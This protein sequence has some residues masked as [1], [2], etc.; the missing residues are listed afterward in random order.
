MKKIKET[1]KSKLLYCS[2]CKKS[3]HEIRLLISGPE[4]YIC[5][6]CVEL[7]NEIIREKIEED[8]AEIDEEIAT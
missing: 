5:D 8:S 1:N 6:G 2:F 7:C 3:Q 4:A